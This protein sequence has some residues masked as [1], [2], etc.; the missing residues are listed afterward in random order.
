[1]AIAPAEWPALSEWRQVLTRTWK[2]SGDDNVGLLAAGVAFYGFTAFVPLLASVVLTYGLIAEPETVSEHIQ[3]L[4][5]TL[6][7]EAA[8]IVA[9][10]LQS[11]SGTKAG[12]KGLGLLLAIA[13]AVYGASKGSESPSSTATRQTGR[14]RP[15]GGSRRA[16]RPRPWYG[17]SRASAS[18]STSPISAITTRPTARWAGWSCS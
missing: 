18:A 8:A 14:T 5:K 9:D 7:R 16:P 11:I 2:E 13:V 4:A 10:Q 15:G 3:T 1:M 17:C 12:A 6:P